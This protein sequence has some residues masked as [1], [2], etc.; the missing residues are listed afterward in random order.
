MAKISPLLNYECDNG[1]RFEDFNTK[2]KVKC[3]QCGSHSEILWIASNSPHRQLQTPIVMWRYPN[4]QLGVA[5][6]SDSKT[7]KGA[8]RIEIRS[9]GEYRRHTK[10]LNR[11]LR[12]KEERREEGYRE[13]REAVEKKHR[14]NL[15]WMMGQ[16]TD[17]AARDLYREALSRNKGGHEPLPFSEFFST[18]MEMDRSNYE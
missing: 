5:G 15:A 14:S 10:E 8:E 13:A 11:Q 18:V 17:P 3:P 6:G 7:P 1:H 2:K 12:E 16:E 9:L 4:G